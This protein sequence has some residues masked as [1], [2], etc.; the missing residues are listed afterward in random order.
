MIQS[1][2]LDRARFEVKL[3]NYAVGPASALADPTILAA[4]QDY[5]RGNSRMIPIGKDDVG[6][7]VP[8]G[9]FH[10]SRKIDG[11]FTMLNFTDGQAIGINPGGTVRLGLPWL[12]EAAL[13]LTKSGIQSARIVGE[14]YVHHTERRARVHDVSK[15]AR[16]PQSLDDLQRLRF[17]PFDIIDIDGTGP[18]EEYAGTFQTLETLFSTSGLNQPVETRITT[19]RKEIL[20]IFEQWVEGE[21]AEG[22]VLRGDVAGI[23]K[24]KPRHTLDVVVV[25]FTESTEEREG[26][27]HDLLVA[28]VRS[29][30]ALQI[31]TRVGGGFS[32]S[33]RRQML[34]DLKDRVVESEYVE[35]N[36]D[37]VAY[38]MVRPE[39]VIEISCLDLIS[40]TTRGGNVNRMVVSF[41]EEAAAYRVV[42]RM[43]LATA[44]FPQFVRLREDKQ[45]HP[46]DVS[47]TQV[48]DR[49]EVAM[50]DTDASSFR[51]PRAEVV[52][53]EVFTKVL[54]GETMVRKFVVLKTNKE[55]ATEDYPAYVL[56]YTDYSPN[57]KEPLQ[58]EVTVSNSEDQITALLLACKQANIKKG[59]KET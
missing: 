6:A 50:I 59:W 32:D 21:D 14:L 30:G 56:H 46:E 8:A 12:E 19:T 22:L 2:L 5:R 1:S 33:Q 44:I 3:G 39:W 49:V 16:G 41:S 9:D 35:V 58:R 54:K 4:A 52:K 45:V 20:E 51:L 57:R 29:D 26:L 27:L 34:S 25:G 48:S 42:R 18:S 17:A 47:A 15:I 7:K 37:Y 11:E 53:R 31:L 40:Q 55:N 13:L 24:V 10:V 23:F 43:P 38:Q 28:V 36:S